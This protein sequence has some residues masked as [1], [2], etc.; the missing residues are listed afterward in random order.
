MSNTNITIEKIEEI[1]SRFS[2]MRVMV[3]GDV[4]IDEYMWGSV[5]RIS[6]EAPVPVVE[7]EEV[8]VRLGGAANVVGN[9]VSLGVKPR[10]VSVIGDDRNGDRL[11]SMLDKMGC[12]TDG[13]Y[14]S[15]TRPT[16]IKTRIMAK[17]QQ[18]VRADQELTDDISLEEEKAIEKLFEKHIEEVDAVIISDY[19]KGLISRSFLTKISTACRAKNIFVAVD[20][21]DRYFELYKGLG[22]ITP[23]LKEAYII[24]GKTAPKNSSNDEIV[25]LGWELIDDMNLDYL[26]LTLSE[27]GMALF[28]KETHEFT[29]LP[30][31][32]RKVFDVTGA[33]DTVISLFTTAIAVGATPV[34]AAFL[35]NHAAGI[36]VAELGTASVTVD[37]LL[38]WCR[39]N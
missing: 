25:K 13:L 26:L 1:T 35:A 24:A 37:G 16:T 20:P 8:T 31:V 2:N 11:S 14:R 7:V 12:P 36:T 10:I 39:E 23:N 29:H 6:P 17:H 5:R 19:A 38:T 34:E 15:A 3:I 9:L 30:T 28:E 32:A 18:V 33:G 4:M 27:K 22:V 21:K